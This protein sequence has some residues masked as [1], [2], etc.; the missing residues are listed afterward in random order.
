MQKK[1][2]L[3]ELGVEE[4]PAGYILPALEKFRTGL[5]KELQ[6]ANLDFGEIEEFS[7]PRRFC[8]RIRDLDAEQQDESI[9]RIGPQ[10]EAAYD[11]EGKLTKAAL[12]F[13][14]GAGAEES[15]IY[16]V[17]TGKGEKIAVRLEKKGKQTV[18]LLSDMVKNGVTGMS[19]PKVMKWGATQMQFARPLRWLVCLYGAESINLEINGMKSGR[20]SYG[21]RFRQLHNI[22][23]ISSPGEYESC[24]ERVEVIAERRQRQQQIISGLKAIAEQERLTVITDERLLETVT[25]LVEYPTPGI[26][27][28]KESYLSLPEKIIISTLSQNQK[29]FALRREDGNLANRFIYTSNGNPEFEE[30]IREGNEKVIAARLADAEFYFLEDTAKKLESYVPH[31]KEVLFQKEL[32][33]L[34]EKTERLERLSDYIVGELGIDGELK[35]NI[36]RCAHL[37]KADLVTQMLGEKEFTKLQGY[38]GKKYAEVSGENLEVAQ[39]IYEHYQP[40]G[41]EDELPVSSSGIVV[42]LADKL[43]T[44]CGIMGVGLVPTGS[45][46][47]YALRRAANGIVSILAAK[48]LELSLEK[49]IEQSFALLAAKLP[50]PGNNKGVVKDFFRQRINWLLKQQGIG[51]DVIESVMHIDH[52]NIPDLLQRARDVESFRQ[53]DDF[54]RLVLGFKRV[55]NIISEVK[56]FGIVEESLLSEDAEKRL[57]QELLNLEADLGANLTKREYRI[58][59]EKLVAYSVF[60]DRFFDDVMVNVEEEQLRKNRYNLLGQIRE[61]FLQIADLALVVVED[62]KNK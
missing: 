42:A 46:D 49:L 15:A 4:I 8:L 38:I 5:E 10:V 35:E 16:K 48:G 3:I 25:D 37:A 39:G 44:V 20:K 18:S 28:F 11:G 7:T 53:R 29:C 55:S 56:E 59:M 9:E 60:I 32:G 31:L 43:D 2:M 40:R 1:D 34:L 23:E 27:S 30:I 52:S 54:V 24:L 61:K 51:Y 19:F 26:G 21:N 36:L 41:Q 13:L 33:N 58:I 22:V 57:W 14:R 17:A 6:A 62:K 12:G 50:E 45:N 47:P